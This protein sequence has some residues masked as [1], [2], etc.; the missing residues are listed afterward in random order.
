M[1][2]PSLS[3]QATIIKRLNAAQVLPQHTIFDRGGR[4]EI[5]PC[6]IVGEAHT[7]YPDYSNNFH[8]Q[9][10]ADLHVWTKE[11]DLVSAKLIAGRARAAIFKAPWLVEGF[12]CINLRIETSR[13][14]RDPDGI[15][16]HAVLSVTAVLLEDVKL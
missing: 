5:F 6:I 9:T 4:P 15:H 1:N 11:A 12:R 14:L 7:I 10:V 13:F 16:S 2:D 8:I 3:V